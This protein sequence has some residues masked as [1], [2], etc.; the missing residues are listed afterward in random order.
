MGGLRFPLSLHSLTINCITFGTNENQ[1]IADFLSSTPCLKE[2]S[3]T[4]F[5]N[6]MKMEPIFEALATNLSLP[7]ERLELHCGR[8][9]M[10][11]AAYKHLMTFIKEK[12]TLQYF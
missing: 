6:K 5:S 4:F 7:L 11:M 9:Q 12:S 1:T 8:S 10:N 2:L 3:L